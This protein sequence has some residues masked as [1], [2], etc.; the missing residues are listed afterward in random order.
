MVA[1]RLAARRVS[2]GS[3]VGMHDGNHRK[4]RIDRG[5]TIDA[6]RVLVRGLK[7]RGFA[8]GRLCDLAPAPDPAPAAASLVTEPQAP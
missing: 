8:F 2:D 7:A 5:R 6:T 4:P 3:L 1:N